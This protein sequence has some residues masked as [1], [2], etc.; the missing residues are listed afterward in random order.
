MKEHIIRLYEYFFAEISGQ[1][2]FTFSPND[3]QLKMIEN[4]IQRM[5][6]NAGTDWL[7]HYF[8]FVFSKYEDGKTRFGRGI[9]Q[10]N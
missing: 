1:K 10:F 7:F 3:R 5:P 2:M 8:A 9:V 4:F 6:K